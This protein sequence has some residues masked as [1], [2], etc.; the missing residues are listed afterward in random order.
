MKTK[1]FFGK[2][3]GLYLWGNLLAMALFVA[4]LGF[5]VKYGL[6]T[7]THHGED[8]G[9]PNL[10]KM[11]SKDARLLLSEKSLAMMVVDSSYNKRLPGDCVLQ[12]SPEPGMKVK[13][14]HVV[15]VTVNSL[16]SPSFPIPDLIDNSSYREAE[17]K[18][19]ALGYKLLP[20][21]R[22]IGERDWVYGILC[23]GRQVTAGER[24][25]TDQSLTLL[26][27]N[28][29]YG[30][31]DDIDFLGSPDVVYPEEREDGFDD[32]EEVTE[33]DTTDDDNGGV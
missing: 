2:F 19:S 12:Q 21:K 27:G 5:G 22:I 14:G 31:T 8:I 30:D 16:S 26:I 23:H 9:V 29:Q 28:G 20:P 18:L 6:E 24:I 17:A 4:A 15:Y 32:F 7:Y 13:K 3:L 25:S 11:R 33:D 10:I 1:D